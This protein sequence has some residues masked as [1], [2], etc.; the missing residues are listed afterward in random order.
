M[1]TVIRPW[2]RAHGEIALLGWHE[3]RARE[4]F[5]TALRKGKWSELAVRSAGGNISTVRNPPALAFWAEEW[6]VAFG[7]RAR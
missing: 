7:A 1:R 2:W 6:V 5:T 4:R 3:V